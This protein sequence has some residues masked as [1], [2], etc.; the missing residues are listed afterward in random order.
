M[1]DTTAIKGFG[2]SRGG[3]SWRRRWSAWTW[4]CV[5]VS[6]DTLTR[7]GRGRRPRCSRPADQECHSRAKGGETGGSGFPP[8]VSKSAWVP[9]EGQDP[10]L[11]LLFL[12][13]LSSPIN[14]PPF[15]QRASSGYGS[16][17]RAPFPGVL[18]GARQALACAL[19]QPASGLNKG[20]SLARSQGQ[21]CLGTGLC[22]RESRSPPLHPL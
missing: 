12:L 5:C 13:P 10:L 14:P 8:P 9:E 17:G 2:L 22:L 1:C 15:L 19:G 6:V 20:R 4:F 21:L 18:F 7:R 11:G 16:S 3:P